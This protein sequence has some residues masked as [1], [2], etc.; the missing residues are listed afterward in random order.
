M[1]QLWEPAVLGPMTLRNRTVRSATNEHLSERD[2]ALTA[3]WAETQIELARNEVGLVITGHMCVD[4]RQRADEGQPVLDRDTDLSLLRRAADGVHDSG[5]RIVVQLSHTGPKAPAD[6]N[7]TMPK[8]PAD[9][10]PEELDTLV[11][12]FAEAAM[13]CKEAGM[14]GVQVHC[15][16]GYLLSSFLNPAQNLRTDRYGGSLENR[17][18]LPARI[19]SAIRSACGSDFALLVK[20]DCNGSGDFHGLL[21]LFQRVGVDGAEVSGVDFNNRRGI[22]SPFYLKEVL[23]AREGIDLPLILVGGIF[24]QKSAQTVLDAGIPFVSFSRALICQPD[25]LARMKEGVI[26]ESPCLACNGCYKVYRQRPVRCVTHDQ[27]IPQLKKV[28]HPV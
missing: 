8:S 16:H 14:D 24:S 7:G 13:R 4:R 1:F 19:L 25:F 27:P 9:F 15:A 5:G 6:L 10:T 11:N 2:G 26:E 21:N 12:Q 28:F 23:E 22:K 3:V 17:F 18:R 20:V